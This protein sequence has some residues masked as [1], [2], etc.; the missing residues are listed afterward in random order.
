MSDVLDR[1]S[2]ACSE[3]I[4]LECGCDAN[5]PRDTDCMHCEHY[6][7][8]VEAEFRIGWLSAYALKETASNSHL[9]ADA[10]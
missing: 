8:Y 7:N 6:R 4:L 5:D 3:P 1:M 10:A 2:R 9:A